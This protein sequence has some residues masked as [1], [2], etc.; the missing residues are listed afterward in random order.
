[1]TTPFAVLVNDDPAQL[2]VLSAL[3]RKAGLEPRTF[4]GAEAAL[5]DMS[6]RAAAADG[7]P[8]ALPAL[9]VTD[10]YMPGIDGWRFCRLLRSPEYAAFNQVPI[11]LVS[12]TYAG[13]E[14]DR[15]AADLGAE[16][17]LPS[18]VD[19]KRFVEQVRAIL[20]GRQV[21]KPLRALIVEDD[22]SLAGILKKALA[23]H[24]YQADTALTARAAADA[25]EKAA[26]DVAVLD[27]HLPDGTGDSLLDAFRAERPDC[28]CLM[29]TTD[30]GPE[31]ALDWMKRGA[32][33]YLRKPFPP[34][35]LIELCERARRE[36][37]LL[38]VRDVLEV[39]TRELRESEEKHRILLERSS[40]PIFSFT[41]EGRYTY[42]NPAFAEG[43]GKQVED[44][45]GKSIWDVFPKEEAYKRFASLSQV[46][47]TGE[48]EV[49]E[50]R[51][52]RADGDRYHMTTITPITDA[53]GKVVSA[54]CS[55][56][57]ITGR[58]RAEE[59]L[60]ESHQRLEL[61]LDGG[62]LGM[63][64][65]NLQTDAVT[66]SD[67]WAQMLEYRPDEVEP[68]VDFFKRHVHPED[69]PAVLDRLTGHIE[70]RM[71][72]YASEHR[73][74]TKSGRLFWA[75]D[76]G[77]IVE[78]DKDG[79]PVR[80]AGTIADITE[81]KRAEEALYKSED[82]FK[83]MVENAFEGTA[84]ISKEGVVLYATPAVE[85]IAGLGTDELI[86]TRFLDRVHPD[87][88]HQVV[89]NMARLVGKPGSAVAS[90][91]RIEFPDGSYHHVESTSTNLVD[92]P[93]VG[94]I[95]VNFRDITERK[96]AEEEK[97]GLEAQLQQAQRMELVGRLAG[98]VAHDFN[99]MLG[100]ILGHAEVALG[101]VGPDQPVRGHLAEIHKA[102]KRS[103]NLT[104]QLLAFARKQ[105]IA[106]KVLDLN[107]TV[108]GMLK[109]LRRLIGEDIDLR[110]QPEAGL[111]PVRVDPSQI[112][113][114]LANLC[115]NARDAIADVGKVTI[116]TGSC[117]LDEGYCAA[118][119][120]FV[121][122]EY[123][124]L[125]VS[126]DGCG[127]D[128][129]TL[130]HVFEPF[131]TTK[132]VGMGTGLGLPTV[133]GI[134]K[135]NNGFI[136]VY[137][138]PGQGT[139]FSIY[140]P[141]HAGKAEQARTEDA[142]EPLVRG[143]ETILLVEDERAILEMTTEMLELHG[144]VVLAAGTPGE[145]IRMA[146]EHAGE[147]HLLMTDVVMPEMN[148]RDLAKNLLSIYPHLKRLFT[149]G[150]TAN[151]IAHR[152]VLDDGVHFLQ[153]PFSMKGLAAK[154]REALESD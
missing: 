25:F 81:R 143:Q 4:T 142:G 24:G 137:S 68:S 74:R 66:Y 21:L 96:R 80:V 36:R 41:P 104:R 150:Y 93:S 141:R 151:L 127:M 42:V 27:Y 130:A 16:A 138:E 153:K 9:V 34:D 119:A 15:I 90:T 10:L 70:G 2:K 102:A 83:A 18:P 99:N 69:L 67:R 100:V 12:A 22:K 55:S 89:Q 87:D 110:W 114:I 86:G 105:T 139:T 97:A 145:A 47:R 77:R 19:G 56:K 43:V 75:M 17:F 61:A 91:Y 3:V 125:A 85:Q 35:Y 140:L 118:H 146:R 131:F 60:R 88:M 62:E 73:L 6:A 65:W 154:V 37:A 109:M 116:E 46:V 64:D 26:Y 7:D 122:G 136:N 152:G 111:W 52:P 31:L 124:R 29:M 134:V 20:K 72:V 82:R 101:R 106:P 126:D 53:A 92:R 48:E 133:Y 98:G 23:A 63:W 84:V 58:R 8:D 121:P 40:D 135:Q 38:R 132:G 112:D 129:E 123:V 78:R 128:K 115:A 95:V 39:R 79:R 50:V 148:G 30:P 14:V 108:E 103:A 149:S 57:D 33:A 28:V 11:L 117:A 51:V 94:G 147:I 120:G 71:R 13:E 1:V 59:A 113:Q 44:I 45:I 5:A 107:E 32:A 144:Y 49:V 76:H 54:I